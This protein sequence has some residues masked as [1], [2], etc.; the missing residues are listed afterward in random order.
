MKI[1]S[2]IKLPRP[3]DLNWQGESRDDLACLDKVGFIKC[4][5]PW[6]DD[7]FLVLGYIYFASKA[8]YF[9]PVV[10]SHPQRGVAA[11][12]IVLPLSRDEIFSYES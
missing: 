4:I 1:S 7:N 9:S 5:I 10:G 6:F 8:L 12:K 11:L 3:R 2:A